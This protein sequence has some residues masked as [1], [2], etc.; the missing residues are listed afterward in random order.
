MFLA[1]ALTIQLANIKA[2][3]S[4]H[5]ARCFLLQAPTRQTAD[6]HTKLCSM[7]RR[8]SPVIPLVK[9]RPFWVV[10]AVGEDGVDTTDAHGCGPF[11]SNA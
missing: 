9:T 7:K 4:V 3:C 6:E 8:D 1:D 2:N 5:A 10:V 11:L